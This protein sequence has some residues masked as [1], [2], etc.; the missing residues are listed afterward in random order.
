MKPSLGWPSLVPRLSPS[1]CL[2]CMG[3][4]YGIHIYGFVHMV[5]NIH[6]I[7]ILERSQDQVLHR[8]T[9]QSARLPLS[10]LVLHALKSRS[11]NNGELSAV[12]QSLLLANYQQHSDSQ[13]SC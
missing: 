6:C 5:F 13:E 4:L 2:I 10:V 12:I 8:W 3:C 9:D 11:D 1:F 7:H